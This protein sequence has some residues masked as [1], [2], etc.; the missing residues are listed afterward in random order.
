MVVRDEGPSSTLFLIA[1]AI[2][3]YAWFGSREAPIT[4][5]YTNRQALGRAFAAEFLAPAAGVIQMVEDEERSFGEV[6]AHY[7]VHAAVVQHQYDNAR[8]GPQLR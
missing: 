7:G 4:D 3:D 1:R 2:G 8:E 6:A 5:R